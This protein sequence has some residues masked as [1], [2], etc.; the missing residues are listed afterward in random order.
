MDAMRN[1]L[2]LTFMPKTAIK[3]PF[4]HNIL[5]IQIRTQGSGIWSQ[6]RIFYM[7]FRGI[8]ES[9]PWLE[10]PSLF[11]AAVKEILPLGKCCYQHACKSLY[12]HLFMTASLA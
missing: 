4:F 7:Y 2:V 1:Y 3:K 11:V 12:H 8:R 5:G 6:Q 10:F 9:C